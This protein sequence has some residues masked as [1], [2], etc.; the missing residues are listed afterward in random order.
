V[1]KVWASHG[2]SGLRSVGKFFQNYSGTVAMVWPA[3]PA[4]VKGKWA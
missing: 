3:S 4:F 1:G 2:L